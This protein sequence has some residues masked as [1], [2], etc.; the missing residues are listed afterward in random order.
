MNLRAT[1]RRYA[2]FIAAL[3]TGV[4]GVVTLVISKSVLNDGDFTPLA[5]LWAMWAVSA[6]ALTYGAQQWSA[7]QPTG[8]NSLTTRAGRPLAVALV[9]LSCIVGLLSFLLRTRLFSSSAVWWPLLAGVLPFGS[10][11]VGLT[12]GE[13]ARTGR[14]YWLAAVITGENTIRLV[15]V[16]VLSVLGAPPEW[17]GVGLAAGF[18]MAIVPPIDRQVRGRFDVRPLA[19]AVCVGLASH[20][21]LFGAPLILALSGGSGDEAVL[22]F[23]V[24]SAGRAPF[25]FLQALIPEVAVRFGTDHGRLLTTVRSLTSIGLLGAGA[26]FVGGALLGDTIVGP[27][28]SIRGEVDGEIYGLVGVAAMISIALSLIT[29]RLVA[30]STSR[31]LVLAWSLPVVATGIA[32][33]S[34]ALGELRS[35]VVWIV[36]VHLY[37]AIA[38]N[39]LTVRQQTTSD[40]TNSSMDS[41]ATSP[42]PRVTT[43]DDPYSS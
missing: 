8:I 1:S 30:S 31:P 19:T 43:E 37:V 25:V 15:A 7:V 27:V 28:F 4:Q 3:L 32:M 35:V 20:A 29:V 24:L 2:T 34:G 5:Q 23:L 42:R 13:L 38:I 40:P 18:L 14:T 22:L 21:L 9:A 16:I 33:A 41:L 17:Y 10:C 6:A 26:A 39:I 36:G 12:R 11:L